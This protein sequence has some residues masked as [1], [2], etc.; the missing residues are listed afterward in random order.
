MT[1]RIL[2][3][4]DDTWLADCYTRWLTSAGYHVACYS[5]AQAALEAMDAQL[6]DLV[7]LDI[8]LHGANGLQFLHERQSYTD[9]ARIPVIVCSSAMPN[10]VP[11]AYGVR[12]ILDK[13]TL[14]PGQLRRA[15]ARAVHHAAA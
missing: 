4:E 15:V 7:L 14:T 6:P 3:V 10:N 13:T 8:M 12:E 11:A 2:V 9:L 5:D 1:Y